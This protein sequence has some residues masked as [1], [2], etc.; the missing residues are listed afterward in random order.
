MTLI[1]PS[2]DTGMVVGGTVTIDDYIGMVP[3]DSKF[4][5]IRWALGRLKTTFPDEVDELTVDRVQGWID[6]INNPEG[7]EPDKIRDDIFKHIVGSETI[8]SVLGVDAATAEALIRGGND[9]GINFSE[10]DIDELTGQVLGDEAFSDPSGIMDGGRLTK[11]VR[12]GQDPLWAM[13]YEVGGIQHVYTFDSIEQMYA[14]LGRNAVTSGEF[15]YLELSEDTLNDGDTW[16]LGSAAAFVGDTGQTY[17]QYFDDVMRQA[18]LEA[19]VRNPGKLGE[20]LSDPTIQRIIA[21]GQAADWSEARIKAEI[22]NTDYYQNTLYPGIIS[23]LEQ[24]VPDPEA[25]WRRYAT[26]VESSLSAL[27]YSRDADGTYSTLVGDML[28]RGIK[29]EDFT[30]FAPTFVRA[31]Q[32]QDFADVLNQW[33]ER[34]LGRSIEFEDWFSVLE[35]TTTPDIAEVVERATIQFQAE[36]TDTALSPQQISRLSELTEFSEAQLATAF[37]QA[38]QALLAVGRQ[39]LGRFG[40]T[41]SALVN[42]AFGVETLGADPISTSGEALTANEVQRRVQ[43]AATELGIQDDRKA[44]LF[45]GFDQRGRPVREGLRAVRP[46]VG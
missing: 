31:E 5:P 16:V 22:R 1:Q 27:G 39:E 35:G 33:T 13:T 41:E 2:D 25:A 32:S 15:G 29:A 44:Q 24:G 40:L 21:E 10:L 37:S 26:D 18:A 17:Q 14:A 20:Y 30:A 42:S 34:D 23:F 12:P 11:I 8:Q 4:D 38:E 6:E 46:E 43:K 45:V 28:G 36:R 3:A 9:G 7:R 19:G